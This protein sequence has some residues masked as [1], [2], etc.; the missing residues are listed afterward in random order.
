M[1]IRSW[2]SIFLLCVGSSA[3][4]AP[5]SDEAFTREI[6]RKLQMAVPTHHFEYRK[7]LEL[8]DTTP[9]GKSLGNIYLDR[10]SQFAHSNPDVADLAIDDYVSKIGQA[11]ADR[12]RPISREDLRLAVRNHSVIQRSLAA[13]GAGSKAA[14]PRSLAGDL[15]IVP[16]IDSPASIRYLGQRDLA[17]LEL[18]QQQAEAIAMRNM[19]LLQKPLADI[20]KTP[21]RN[22]IGIINEEYAASRLIWPED[23]ANLAKSA[24]GNLVVMAPTYDTVIYGAGTTAIQVDALRSLGLNIAKHSQ[25]PL[26]ATVLRLT[27]EG[28]EVVH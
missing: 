28:W 18:S 26:S 21:P 8:C 1:N 23:W 10:V 14:Y 15:D 7:P 3:I 11:I 16:V 13:L 12:E 2:I 9:G 20:T 6:L 22:G 27:H 25:V 4:A 19:R 17:T 24:G 5:S